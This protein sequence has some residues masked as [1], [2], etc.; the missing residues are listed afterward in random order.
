MRVLTN[1]GVLDP[2]NAI[3][4]YSEMFGKALGLLG[5]CEFIEEETLRTLLQDAGFVNITLGARCVIPTGPWPKDKRTK[6]AGAM[7]L[8]AG[9]SGYHAYGLAVF[10]RVLGLT[11]EEAN[12]VC[13]EALAAA[14]AMRC[15]TYG[16][17]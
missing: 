7:N 11:P 12:K 16:Y 14:K 15:H 9:E 3:R 10:T 8:L 4:I 1:L 13:D 6:Q 2:N 5:R 17:L